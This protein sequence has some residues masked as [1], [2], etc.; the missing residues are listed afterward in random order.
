MKASTLT[1]STPRKERTSSLDRRPLLLK[2]AD[3]L[4][5]ELAEELRGWRVVRLDSKGQGAARPSRMGKNRTS[6]SMT[7]LHLTL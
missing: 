3:E 2:L 7:H 1:Y 5:L 4:E 6:V